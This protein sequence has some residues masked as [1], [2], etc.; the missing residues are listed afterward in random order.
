MSTILA[1]LEYQTELWHEEMEKHQAQQAIVDEQRIAV[2]EKL[3]KRE[4]EKKN[5]KDLLNQ[6]QRWRK[7]VDLRDF[8]DQVEKNA[9]HHN[10]MSNELVKWLS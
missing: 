3:K 6:A 1:N 7:T 9:L 2:Q 10:A 4:A 8:I 5:F